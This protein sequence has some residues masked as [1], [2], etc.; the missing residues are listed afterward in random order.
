MAYQ[1]KDLMPADN[2]TLDDCALSKIVSGIDPPAEVKC[3]KAGDN[4]VNCSPY[5]M[6]V[7]TVLFRQHNRIAAELADLNGHWDDERLY[8][9]A[10]RI[11]IAQWQ[12]IV[13]SEYLPAVI[14]RK[15]MQ[16]VG[17]FTLE[18]GFSGDYD[19]NVNPSILNEFS[20]AAFRFGHSQVQGR[21][22]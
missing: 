10:R 16:Q 2:E 9:E 17:I 7:Q 12:H 3:F 8:E 22:R 20:S 4:R 18:N 21:Q 6:V 15:K 13:Y 19:Q 14:G 5:L 1:V 11:L